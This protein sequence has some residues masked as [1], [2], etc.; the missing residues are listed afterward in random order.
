MW[1]LLIL[2]VS[3]IM[4]LEGIPLIKK[5]QSRELMVFVVLL[6]AACALFIG[7]NI[8]LQPPLKSLGTLFDNLGKNLFG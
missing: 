1:I 3:V 4:L 2:A 6:M 8:G 5:K 7:S